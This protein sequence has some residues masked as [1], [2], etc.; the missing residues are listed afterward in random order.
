MNRYM[1]NIMAFMIVK[2]L[3][4]PFDR[5]EAYNLKLI[6]KYGNLIN[7][8]KTSRERDALTYL[9]KLVF[10]IKRIIN[11]LPGGESKFKNV[12]VAFYMLR[13]H[14]GVSEA[15]ENDSFDNMIDEMGAGAAGGG[16]AN[17]TGVPVSTHEPVIRKR[18][19][20]KWINSNRK[21]ARLRKNQGRSVMGRIV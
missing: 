11:K 4:T 13:N 15:M 16:H 10:S 6:D 3:L 1:Q 19:V 17:M 18:A 12:M 2:K 14:A 9:D 5:T 20:D 8:P 7:R 21:K